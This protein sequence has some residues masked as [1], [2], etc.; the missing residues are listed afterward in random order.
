MYKN[1]FGLRENPFNINPDPRF[2][3]LTP[4]AREAIA[5]LIYGIQ[6]HKG[7][8]LLTGEA[9]T[10]KTTLIN[11]LLDWL[12][13]QKMS[14]AF[15]FN[16]VLSPSHLFD[17][18]LADFA[19][20]ADFRPKSSKLKRLNTWLIERSRTGETPVLIVDEAQGLSLELLEEIRLLLNS[21]NGYQK[22]LQI[23]LA[24]W[25]ELE[26]K[27]RRPELRGLQ[28][29]ISLR[30]NT[31]PLT[32]RESCEYITARL[33]IGGTIGDS[34]FA[35]DAMDAVHFYSQGIP[36]VINLLC[37]QALINAYAENLRPVPA[38]MV[39]EAARDFSLDE[40]LP[41]AAYCSL[42]N[43]QP[44]NLVVKDSI[45]AKDSEHPV[46]TKETNVPGS[47]SATR[48]SAPAAV[49]VGEPMLTTGK[50]SCASVPE[51]G[52]IFHSVKGANIPASLSDSIPVL[53]DPEAQSNESRVCLDSV[54]GLS[55]SAAQPIEGMIQN[56][57]I[58][59]PTPLPPLHEISPKGETESSPLAEDKRSSAPKKLALRLEIMNRILYDSCRTR[60]RALLRTLK[61]LHTS[62]ETGFLRVISSAARSRVSGAALRGIKQSTFRIRVLLLRWMLD[63]KC[64]WAVMINA[65]AL[66]NRKNS[67]SQWLRQPVHPV[68][69]RKPRRAR[70]KPV[71]TQVVTHWIFDF[72]RDWAAMIN[73]IAL[74]N[75]RKSFSQWLRQ[76]FHP[77][78]WRES[79]RARSKPS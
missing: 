25:P 46:R 5:T 49:G 62:R 28:Q 66:P 36:R 59:S 65:I 63:F 2:L 67:F 15:I 69:W 51:R 31:A 79:R 35:P 70:S 22:L 39:E 16:S 42:E 6:N 33:R 14:T 76:P 74:P 64:D 20:P 52:D 72:K 60:I 11:Y 3:Y 34:V 26:D 55:N 54:I 58:G 40:F 27:L 32:R 29:R 48:P 56:P 71:V 23:V 44:T 10:G 4:Q 53:P 73:A 30:C 78:T 68:T 45:V 9:G 43:H 61:A 57:A 7:I 8:I 19:I 41:V 38:R 75:R 47:L 1:F 21:E 17:F 12:R 77:V 18:I 50:S 24:G 37:E 13:H